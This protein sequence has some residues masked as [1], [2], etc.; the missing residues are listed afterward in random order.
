MTKTRIDKVKE[1]LAVC[2]E[3]DLDGLELLE[4]YTPRELSHIYNGIGPES[5]PDWLREAVDALHPSLEAVALIHDV[6]WSQP[7]KTKERFDGSNER[8]KENGYKVA[9]HNYGWWNPMRYIVMNQ[10]RRFGNYCSLFGESAF[11]AGKETP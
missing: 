11:R 3:C 10:A 4:K 6:E 1:L 5:F 2:R 7:D 9:K 8:F